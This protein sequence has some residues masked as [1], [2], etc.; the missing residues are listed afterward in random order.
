MTYIC[1]LACYRQAESPEIAG[2]EK[3]TDIVRLTKITS[4]VVQDFPSK[5]DIN[6]VMLGVGDESTVYIWDDAPGL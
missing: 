5:P 3:G 1:G 2:T 4:V 6:D